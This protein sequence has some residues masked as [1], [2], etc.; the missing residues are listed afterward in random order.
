MKFVTLIALIV[1]SAPAMA[2][3]LTAAAVIES[4]T[5]EASTSTPGDLNSQRIRGASALNAGCV[6]NE[7]YDTTLDAE[8]VVEF[9]A[10]DCQAEAPASSP[11]EEIDEAEAA[12]TPTEDYPVKN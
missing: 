10:E 2:Q 9:V 12:A 6:T 4:D 5:V 8:D 3:D 11:A 1:L 7:T